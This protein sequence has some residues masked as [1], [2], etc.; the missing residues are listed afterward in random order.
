VNY[1]RREAGHRAARHDEQVFNL[2]RDV[3]EEAPLSPA[4]YAAVFAELRAQLA[5][6]IAAQPKALRD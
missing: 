2:T 4:A 6:V 5:P 1:S 3:R